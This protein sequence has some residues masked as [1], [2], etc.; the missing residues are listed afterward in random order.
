[1]SNTIKCLVFSLV[2]SMFLTIMSWSEQDGAKILVYEYV[3]N[4]SLLEY[5][6]GKFS[7]Y[8]S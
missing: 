7:V 1:V 4:G 2:T 6:M 8:P 3:P 5:I